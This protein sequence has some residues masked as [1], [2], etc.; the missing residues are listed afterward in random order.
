MNLFSAHSFKKYIFS[1]LA[2]LLITLIILSVLSIIF[3]L[4]PPP[5]LIINGVQN[6]SFIFTALL[7]SFLS[8]RASSKKGLVT[9]IITAF[10]FFILVLTAGKIFFKATHSLSFLLKNFGII[11]ICGAIGGIMGINSK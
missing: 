2:A 10:L 9:G 4:C 8:A 3:A 11:A 5:P 6:Y 7:S 1:V